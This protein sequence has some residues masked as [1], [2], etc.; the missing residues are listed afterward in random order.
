[1]NTTLQ[2]STGRT[3]GVRLSV[4]FLDSDATAGYR[5][6]V[7]PSAPVPEKSKECESCNRGD[8]TTLSQECPS[9]SK[10]EAPGGAWDR[11]KKVHRHESSRDAYDQAVT[12]TRQVHGG[13]V[14]TCGRVVQKSQSGKEAQG[15]PIFATVRYHQRRSL[16]ASHWRECGTDESTL[17]VLPVC[18]LSGD[19]VTLRGFMLTTGD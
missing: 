13:A 17:Q 19:V 14:E 1:M 2:V 12:V 16:E 5:G 6:W 4:C 15:K 18:L 7:Q 9:S 3:H 8:A 10:K 11:I